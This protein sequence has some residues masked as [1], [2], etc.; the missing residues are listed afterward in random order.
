[1]LCEPILSGYNYEFNN[2]QGWPGEINFLRADYVKVEMAGVA[3]NIYITAE[4]L[5]PTPFV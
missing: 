5:C 1:M 4:Y 3:F 2:P